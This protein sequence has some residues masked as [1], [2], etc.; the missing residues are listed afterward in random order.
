MDDGASIMGGP[1]GGKAHALA[2]AMTN[3]GA[4]AF[5]EFGFRVDDRQPAAEVLRLLGY[6][7]Q[8]RPA[9]LLLPPRAHFAPPRRLNVFMPIHWFMMTCPPWTT[10]IC[11][12]GSLAVIKCL[13]MQPQ[14]WQAMRCK[15]WR[16]R[17]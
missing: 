3:T 9:M 14:S 10:L 11:A 1:A 5:E 12:V 6:Y 2:D 8:R 7:V 13:V 15:Q 17:F 4:D 16:L